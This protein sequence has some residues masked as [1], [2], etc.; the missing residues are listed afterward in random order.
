M[1]VLGVDGCKG[2]WIAA[3]RRDD[4]GQPQMLRR[5]SFR[6]LLALVP[7][8]SILA[9]DVPIGLPSAG[10]RACDV[11]ARRLLGSR[12]SSV[13]P[14][15]LRPILGS[16][17]HSDASAIRRSI[18]GKGMSIQAF[19]ILGKV[20]EVDG[21]LNAEPRNR[22]I[23]R[24]VHPEVCFFFLNG[25]RPLAYSKKAYAGREER[26]SLLRS[27]FGPGADG[28]VNQR[29]ELRCQQDDIVDALVGLWTAERI[30]R[31]EAVTLPA[32]PPHDVLGIRMEIVA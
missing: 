25:R 27:H 23:V 6:D 19:G 11:E 20:A 18:E 29:F 13:F 16:H 10:A 26:L 31:G 9:V 17:S 8:P 22:S 1:R 30:L 28:A 12:R 2:G 24:E 14:A 5:D 3:G 32:N 4:N 21:L 7:A 15:P